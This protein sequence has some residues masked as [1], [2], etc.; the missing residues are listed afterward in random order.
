MRK[1]KDATTILWK[2]SKNVKT[3]KK[4]LFKRAEK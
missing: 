3:L 1:N 4:M 2:R